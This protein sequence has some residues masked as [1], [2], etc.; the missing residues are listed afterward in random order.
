ME[1]T[2]APGTWHV[3]D[4]TKRVDWQLAKD[5][6]AEAALPE[7]ERVA[8]SYAASITYTDLAERVQQVT[9]YR[10]KV[11]L[12]N[13][14]GQVL[15]VVLRRTLEEDLPPLTSLVVHKD[16]GGVGDGYYNRDHAQ[17]SINDP[18]LLQRIAAQDRLACYRAYCSDVP[19]DA[20]PQMTELF[21]ER[22]ARSTRRQD[23]PPERVC[24][25]CRYVLPLAGVC[26]FCG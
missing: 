5:A 25:T 14:I 21:A 22:Q 15:E 10:T 11:L 24:P 16:T 23:P 18:G 12:A 1:E 4:P 2:N 19:A 9:G 17:G 20:A 26:D 13:W 7:L 6:W 8:G 3:D